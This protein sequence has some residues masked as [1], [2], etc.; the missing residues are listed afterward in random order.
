M[1]PSFLGTQ[2]NKRI[3]PSH[4]RPEQAIELAEHQSL[5]I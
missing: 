2:N 5:I 1:Y 4:K 3:P